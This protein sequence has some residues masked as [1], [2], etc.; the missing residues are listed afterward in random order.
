MAEH[1]MEKSNILK[2][3]QQEDVKKHANS[4]DPYLVSQRPRVPVDLGC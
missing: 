4:N 3:N 1:E 2:S